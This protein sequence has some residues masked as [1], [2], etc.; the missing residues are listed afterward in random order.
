MQESTVRWWLTLLSLHSGR[1]SVE[2]GQKLA[3]GNPAEGPL[4]ERLLKERAGDCSQGG[5]EEKKSSKTSLEKTF[6]LLRILKDLQFYGNISFEQKSKQMSFGFSEL[7][8]NN[9]SQKSTN[10]YVYLPKGC[11]SKINRYFP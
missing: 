6:F 2:I 11:N 9:I 7:V 8:F 1:V 5:E 3:D 10:P 4:E